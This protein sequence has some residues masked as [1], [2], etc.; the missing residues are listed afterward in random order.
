MNVTN[1]K[2]CRQDNY[3]KADLR[4]WEINIPSAY[5]PQI[6]LPEKIKGEILGHMAELLR[7]SSS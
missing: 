6:G 5:T 3:S 2:S 4:K 7:N 1:V